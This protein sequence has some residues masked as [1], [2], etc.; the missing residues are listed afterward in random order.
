MILVKGILLDIL[1]SIV[2]NCTRSFTCE[3]EENSPTYHKHKM[4]TE[5]CSFIPQAV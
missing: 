3:N 4:H 5:N 1:E 2:N